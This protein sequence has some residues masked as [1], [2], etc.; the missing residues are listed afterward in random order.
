MRTATSSKRADQRARRAGRL[1]NIPA[2]RKKADGAIRSLV[3]ST[4]L[5]V[6]G[7]QGFSKS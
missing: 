6:A 3:C 1:R 4:G 7:V 2:I 5:Y